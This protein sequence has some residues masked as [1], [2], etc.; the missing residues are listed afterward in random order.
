VTATLVTGWVVTALV[1][2]SLAAVYKWRWDA[3]RRRKAESSAYAQRT[4]DGMRASMQAMG[5]ERDALIKASWAAAADRKKLERI[6]AYKDRQ[7]EEL[8]DA[9]PSLIGQMEPA[10]AAAVVAVRLDR[11][12][13]RAA[14]AYAAG[15][16]DGHETRLPPGTGASMGAG[17]ESK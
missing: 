10:K 8:Q 6:I 1:G 14:A 15:A 5:D 2:A 17:P 9:L 13:S 12:L 7:I 3:E 4:I 11:V 16:G